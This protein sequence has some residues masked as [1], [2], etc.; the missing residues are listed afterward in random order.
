MAFLA[1]QAWRLYTQPEL[2]LSKIYKAKYCYDHDMLH[3]TVG[4][5][6][7]FCWR[8]IVKGFELVRAGSLQ[9]L[10]GNI[11]WTENSSGSLDISSAYKL[12]MRLKGIDRGED[13]GVSYQSQTQKFWKEYWKMAVPRKVKIF[14]WRGFHAALPT[15]ISLHRRG[16]ENNVGCG[17]CGY[18]IETYSHAFLHCWFV[19]AVWIQLGLPE[20][21]DLP[22]SVS[23]ADIIHYCWSHFSLQRRQLVLVTLWLIWFNRNKRKHG[24]NGYSLH[25]LIYK[26]KNLSRSFNQCDSKFQSSMKFLYLPEFVWTNP[27]VG[28]IK[29]NCDAS[30]EAS[31]GGG[32][33]IIARDCSGIILAV[34]A[35][36]GV[37]I[38]SSAVCEGIG[39]LE[40]FKLAESL[41]AERVIFETDCADIVQWINICPDVLIAN[42]HWFKASSQM[43][44]HHLDWKVFLI[45]RE[46][47]VVADQ[48]AKPLLLQ[49][50]KKK[51]KKKKTVAV[52]VTRLAPHP[53]YKRRV[54]KKKKY[55]AHD[56]D[57]IFKVGDF[58]Q[59][60]KCRPISKTKTFLAIP[61]PDKRI[62]Q[63]VPPAADDDDLTLQ[64]IQLE[65]ELAA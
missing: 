53:K 20:L 11:S 42:E 1:K 43:L 47:N 2:L 39:L 63:S 50:S 4:Y 33:G 37:G 62:K 9:D 6:P 17:E 14:G 25:E 38:H 15:G 64:G 51:K 59:L 21:C 57:N 27:P 58:V 13:I 29:I 48:L 41:N 19:K 36:R 5:R 54:R 56:P 28:T 55:Q 10:N 40:S 26:A 32:I 23:F 31:R 30:W 65:S 22:D 49:L 52:E 46:A 16:L 45:R 44:H 60:E 34:R 3:C 61:V 24:D 18:N 35:L 12:M 8:S 7:S